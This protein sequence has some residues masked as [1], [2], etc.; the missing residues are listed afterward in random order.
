MTAVTAPALGVP[1][2]P[3]PTP[4]S[5]V[6]LLSLQ[7][8]GADTREQRAQEAREPSGIPHGENGGGAGV[9]LPHRLDGVTTF[10]KD[11]PWVPAA[12]AACYP[13]PCPPAGC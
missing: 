13:L 4:G 9:S 1:A 10:W 6:Y 5:S 11:P 12:E 3:I 8:W 2:G 7:R